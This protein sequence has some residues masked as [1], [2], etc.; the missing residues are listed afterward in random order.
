[1]DSMHTELP[2]IQLVLRPGITDLS[3]GHPDPALLP[4]EQMRL[5]AAEAVG[6][7]GADMLAYG[8]PGG[9]GPL[10][11]W[12]RS[13]ISANEGRDPGLDGLMITGGNSLAL[14]QVCTLLTQP[15]DVV[16]VESP[17]YVYGL[18][19][20]RDHPLDLVPVRTDEQGLSIDALEAALGQLRR[21]GRRPRLF[22]TIPTFHNPTGVSLSAER[23][24]ALLDIAAREGFLIVE[25]DVYR[26]LAYDGP[27]PPSLWSLDTANVVI[28]LGSFAKTLGPGLRLGW[29]TAAPELVERI[30]GGGVLDSGGGVNH[31]TSLM[32]AAFCAA[33]RFDP[34]VEQLRAAYRERSQALVGTLAGSLPEGGR[35][36]AP[37]GGFFTWVTLPEG[38]DTAALLDRAEAHGISYIPGSRFHVEGEG[39]NTLR[40][41]HSLYGPDALVDGAE[42]LVRALLET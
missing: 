30:A 34:Q 39:A 41:S 38:W 4:V 3:W 42:K 40:L 2:I 17:T 28:R 24:R 7:Y 16:L 35:V 21:E 32:V 12:L 9:A 11:A 26:E 29:L 20:L 10:L 33:G 13:R 14:D 22:Y 37:R 6:R 5:S 1:M 23:R 8:N 15:G 19:I 18:R 27:A 36:H 25:D 31:F